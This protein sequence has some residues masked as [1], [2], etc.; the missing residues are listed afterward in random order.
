[1]FDPARAILATSI[2]LT[3]AA[4]RAEPP[5]TSHFSGVP[6]GRVPVAPATLAEHDTP[7]A[8]AVPGPHCIAANDIVGA[9][10]LGD[11]IIE[12]LLANGDRL[13][14]SFAQDCPFLGFYQG[15]YYR[16]S[17]AGRL[18]AGRDSV[19]DRSGSACAIE[20]IRRHRVKRP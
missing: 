12:L 14:M 2:A 16:R 8:A 17:V 15:F 6:M 9:T 5:R 7:D 20:G 18:C 13:H 3:C 10:V 11:R 19:I 1:V 4:A